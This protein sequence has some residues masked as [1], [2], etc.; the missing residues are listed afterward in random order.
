MPIQTSDEVNIMNNAALAEYNDRVR[1]WEL[2]PKIQKTTMQ[3]AP[4]RTSQDVACYCV[5]QNCL[6]HANGGQCVLCIE[7]LKQSHSSS[8]GYL[9]VVCK[10]GCQVRFNVHKRLK[11]ARTFA[12]DANGVA[13]VEEPSTAGFF[14][15]LI[16]DHFQNCSIESMQQS[17]TSVQQ[18]AN[19]GAS[20]A[21]LSIIA[22][23]N[24]QSKTP[25]C[26][27]LQA[28]LDPKTKMTN[29]GVSINTL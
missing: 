5:K 23:P 18:A 29:D 17:G 19:N 10:W 27:H 22:N 26:K 2:L 13:T 9:Q 21:P 15:N 11:I 3:R 1:V 7:F 6:C 16:Q 8:G 20:H 24:I 28:A 14:Y 25:L 12:L 4:S